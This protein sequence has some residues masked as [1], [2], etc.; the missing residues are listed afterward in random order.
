MDEQQSAEYRSIRKAYRV[1][2]YIITGLIV[3]ISVVAV[4]GVFSAW[5]YWVGSWKLAIGLALAGI[6]LLIPGGAFISDMR[7]IS[8]R[9]KTTDQESAGMEPFAA[10]LAA[11]IAALF[12]FSTPDATTAEHYISEEHQLAA[13]AN[14]PGTQTTGEVFVSINTTTEDTTGTLHYIRIETTEDG[15]QAKTLHTWPMDE[16]KIFEDAT[17]PVERH[18]HTR[19]MATNPYTGEQKVMADTLDYVEISV[20]AGSVANNYTIDVAPSS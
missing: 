5:I 18:H 2:C 16:I 7:E 15:R 17:T 13:A 12:I 3:V 4:S 19:W 6:M 14:H 9:Y 11:A 20:P 1:Y 8:L 10:A